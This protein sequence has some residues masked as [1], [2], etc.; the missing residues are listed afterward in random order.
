[1]SEEV[2][3]TEHVAKSFGAVSALEDVSIRL[4]RGEVL[5]LLGSL[6]AITDGEGRHVPQRP[7]PL[8]TSSAITSTSRRSHTARTACA[9]PGGAGTT[10]PAAPT[11]GSN[12]NAAT[13]SEPSASM[14]ASSSSASAATSPSPVSPARGR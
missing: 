2:L 4:N 3:R 6:L 1:M 5:G 12:M 10:P 11:T 14:R 8:I 13:C 9:Y 7:A